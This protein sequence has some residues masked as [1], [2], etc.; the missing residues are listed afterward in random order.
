MQ[1][2]EYLMVLISYGMSVTCKTHAYTHMQSHAT[3]LVLVL[4][5]VQNLGDKTALS[6]RDSIG[7][8]LVTSIL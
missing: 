7:W 3:M 8:A 6:A 5:R 2:E 4:Y 1:L